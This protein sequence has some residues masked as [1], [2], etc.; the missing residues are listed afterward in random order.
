M[1]IEKNTI[2]VMFFFFTL[3][4][5]ICIKCLLML[6]RKR[7]VYNVLFCTQQISS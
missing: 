6:N 4:E 3:M 7:R 2:T 1:S 5:L